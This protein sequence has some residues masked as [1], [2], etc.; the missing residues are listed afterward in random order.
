MSIS[1][2]NA[3]RA[4]GDPDVIATL[5]QAFPEN[6]VYMYPWVDTSAGD[7]P[8]LQEEFQRQHAE[9]P[10]VQIFYHASGIPASEMGTV[11]GYGFVHMLA[12][13][14]LASVL[15]ALAEPSCCY[16]ARVSFVFGL[17]LFATLWIEGANVIWWHYPTSHS[18]FMSAYNVVAWLLAGLVIGAIVK[19][20]DASGKDSA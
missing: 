4:K 8:G 13:A 15:L 20:K 10:V 3:I 2:W 17:G 6:G 14:L 11:M 7:Q 18:V 16:L 12:T 9:G 1:P 5:K 19:K